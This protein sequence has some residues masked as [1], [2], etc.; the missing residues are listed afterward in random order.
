MENHVRTAPGVAPSLRRESHPARADAART[1]SIGVRDTE[2]ERDDALLI[3][4]VAGGS[5]D[6][7]RAIYERY[8]GLVYTIALRIVGDPQLSQEIVQDVFL[9]CW[10]RA[11]SFDANRGRL[12]AWLMGIARNRSIDAV[13]GAQHRARQRDRELLPG[14]QRD[15]TAIGRDH[16]E[17]VALH[18]TIVAAL[19]ALPDV[20]REAIE[21]VVTGGLTQTEIAEVLHVPLGTVKTR[22]RDGMARM[23][24]QLAVDEP[25]RRTAGA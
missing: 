24:T 5:E 17:A 10:E 1:G 22:I 25:E 15:G 8:G 18:L 13:R 11:A 12:A 21:L 23:R 6:A 7:L 14:D 3:S 19:E 20:Q 9:R 4:A 2:P 16:G